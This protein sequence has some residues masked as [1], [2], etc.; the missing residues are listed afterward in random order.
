MWNRNVC[1]GFVTLARTSGFN[2]GWWVWRGLSGRIWGVISPP[3]NWR[4]RFG[5]PFAQPLARVR[6]VLRHADHFLLL[7]P[8][9]LRI[10]IFKL[11]KKG[12]TANNYRKWLGVVSKQRYILKLCQVRH[13]R[14]NAS[15]GVSFSL[16]RRSFREFSWTDETTREGY[17]IPTPWLFNKLWHP[18]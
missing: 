18:L 16:P 9:F 2:I 14:V 17:S 1:D 4:W 10:Q 12:K 3:A 7:Y 6:W 13:E 8:V 15:V 11:L 5:R